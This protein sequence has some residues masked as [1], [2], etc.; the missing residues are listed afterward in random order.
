MAAVLIADAEVLNLG[1]TSVR[2]EGT[3]IA[4]VGDLAPVAGEHVVHARGRLL[5]PGLHDHHCH[6]AA[7]A[8][9]DASVVCGPPEVSD[10]LQLAQQLERPGAGWLRGILYHESVMGL[11]TARELDRLVPHRPLRMQHRGGRMWLLNSPALDLLLAHGEPPPGLERDGNGYTG[12][13]FDED[14][15]LHDAL[16]GTPPDLLAVSARLAAWGVTGVTDMSPRNDPDMAAH[17]QQQRASGAL[18]QRIV[19]A[20]ALSLA[21]APP[22]DWGVGPA[23]L[24][25]HEGALP[26]FDA[27]QG[28]VAAAHAQ[29]RAVAIHCVTEVELVFA[30]AAIE[31]AGTLAGDRIE[32]ASVASPELVARMAEL[33]LAVCVQPH[34]I[35]ERGDRYL[36][37]VEARHLPDLYR[38]QTLADAGIA[39]AGGSDAPFA[40]ADPWSA[41]A[42]AVSRQ[43]VSGAI[44]GR[45]EALSPESALALYLKEPLHLSRERRVAAGSAADLCLIDRPWAQARLDLSKVSALLTVASGRIV[46][47]LI[48]QPPG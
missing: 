39:L 22:G 31:V 19:I 13:L 37:D 1:R 28:F 4:A 30:I 16:G 8:A 24:H 5:L 48:D 33:G 35:A 32:H 47:D 25:L 34:F 43:T 3:R 27:A 18:V 29:G 14:R 7:L 2:I 10:A 26:D 42:A 20:G 12:R 23:K 15:W 46:H 21:H 40:S 36:A 41:M 6:L 11:P 44:I 17:F 38:L 9:R 45:R